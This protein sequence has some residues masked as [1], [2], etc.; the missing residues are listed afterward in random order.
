MELIV[1]LVIAVVLAGWFILTYNKFVQ[2]IEAV[3]NSEKEISVQ[4]DRRGKVFDSLI[5]A[6][7]KYMDHEQGVFA[8]VTELR[9]Q[10]KQGNALKDGQAHQAEDELSKIISSGELTSS[11]NLTMEAYPELKANENMQQLQEEI[12]STENKLTFAKKA[13]NNAIEAYNVKLKS[14]PDM[15]VPAIASSLKKDF[16]YWSLNDEEV[17]Q[18]EARRVEF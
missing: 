9:S 13:F 5:S 12:V 11:L 6:V 16:E 1:I 17:E 3:T 14:I 7:K 10:A 2:M 8:K 4:L 15:F 18:A